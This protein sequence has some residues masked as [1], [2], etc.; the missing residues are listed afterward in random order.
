MPSIEELAGK[1]Y[2]DSHFDRR[3]P[4]DA[5]FIQKVKII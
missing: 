1:V 5:Q 3:I 2:N 4:I